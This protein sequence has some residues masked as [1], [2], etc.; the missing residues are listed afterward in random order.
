M[1]ILNDLKMILEVLLACCSGGTFGMLKVYYS[2]EQI[3]IMELATGQH[4]SVLT[5]FNDPLD[6]GRD[7][8]GSY[9]N[10]ADVLDPLMVWLNSF[11]TEQTL[12]SIVL[13]KLKLFRRDER[14][15]CVIRQS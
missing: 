6:G 13:G 3:T 11:N 12:P 14:F 4:S 7:T 5:Y 8:P 15:K 1:V 2:T 10:V 9:I